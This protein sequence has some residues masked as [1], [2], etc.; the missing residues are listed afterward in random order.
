MPKSARKAL[1]VAVSGALVILASSAPAAAQAP[2]A[3][4]SVHTDE[5]GAAVNLG[6]VGFNWRTGG[7]AVAPLRPSVV[8]SF[9]VRLSRVA[10]APGVF[11]FAAADAEVDAVERTGATPLLVLIERPPWANQAG[12]C[13]YEAAVTA[14]LTHYDVDRL[15]RGHRPVWIESGNE[16]EFPPAA[17]GQLPTELAADV[18]AQ[19]RAVVAV[20]RRRAV[21]VVYGGPAAL[22]ADP[23]VVA[24]FVTV[25][26]AAG[27]APDFVSWHAC[28]NAP[29]LGP[30]G[31]EDT[32]SPAAIAVW[33]ADHGVNPAATPVLMGAG[34]DVVRAAVR[35]VT[36]VGEALPSLAITEWNLSSGGLDRRHDSHVGAA[37]ALGAL[38]EM[39][40]HAVDVSA[41][42][43]SVD[44]HCTDVAHNPTRGEF[45]GDWGTASAGGVR[46]P[47]WFAF[48]LWN[49]LAG[50]VLPMTGDDPNGGFWAMASRSDSTV[51]VLLVAFSAAV[52][53]DRTVQ[54]AL[55]G[56]V[57]TGEPTV[58]RLDASHPDGRPE[59]LTTGLASIA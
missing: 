35:A 56:S 32:S 34:A 58:R 7:A 57:P 27:R 50:Q 29:L 38:V 48:D 40:R 25:A 24:G 8:R 22:F 36:P 54:V 30:D 26:R 37:H 6:L 44:R 45:C 39:Q 23:A 49:R 59:A 51:R 5:R 21:H 55:A 20:E 12:S 18:G 10:P 11:D 13:G 4:I 19:V 31:P 52:P 15:R 9:A 53:R 42:F 3:T 1:R 33:Q 46:K 16:P 17:H 2:A 41:F 28:S 43:A 14:V 47:V